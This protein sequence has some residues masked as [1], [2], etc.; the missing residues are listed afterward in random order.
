MTMSTWPSS[1]RM[2]AIASSFMASEKPSPSSVTALRPAAFASASNARLLYQPAEAV[3]VSPGARS[4][5]TPTVSALQPK[6]AT[7][8][9]ASP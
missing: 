7:I 3:L 1:A 6:A 4:N 9:E 2:A 8:R 5:E